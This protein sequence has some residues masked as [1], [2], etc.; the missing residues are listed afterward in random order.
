MIPIP[1]PSRLFPQRLPRS[2]GSG[3]HSIPV[4][5]LTIASIPVFIASAIFA[6]LLAAAWSPWLGIPAGILGFSIG[7]GLTQESIVVCGITEA[8]FY[9]AVMFI[10]SGGLE[11]ADRTSPITGAAVVATTILC[12]TYAALKDR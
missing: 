8:I 12:L 4:G 10:F 2:S 11:S 6:G 3:R 5:L 1:D 7:M 9:S